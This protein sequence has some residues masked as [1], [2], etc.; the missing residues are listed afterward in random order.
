MAEHKDLLRQILLSGTALVAAGIAGG[1]CLSAA[2]AAEFTVSDQASFAAAMQSI[3]LDHANSHTLNITSSF[4]MTGAVA[5]VVLDDGQS[6][7]INGNGNT[8][9]G[10]NQFRPFFISSSSPTSSGGPT[11][12][13]SNLNIEGGAATGGAGA[14]GGMGA[15]GGLFVD[16][17]TTVVLDLVNFRNNSATGGSA[18]DAGGGGGL[19]G[20]GGAG[21]T[22]GGGGLYGEGGSSHSISLDPGSGAGGGGALGGGGPGSTGGGGGGGGF[23]GVGGSADSGTAPGGGGGGGF[24]GASGG[25][26]GDL[27]GGGG[28]GLTDAGDNSGGLYGGAGGGSPAQGG[29]GGDYE[30]AGEDA[31][32]EGGGGGGGGETSPGGAGNMF[33]GGGGG[34]QA[35]SGN[36]SGGAGGFGG[37]GGGAG[38]G[39]DTSSGSNGGAGG[40]FGGG[41]GAEEDSTA[42][43][44][45]GGDFGG[46]GGGDD[47]NGG[48]GGFGGGGGSSVG[49][50]AGNGGFGGG[51]AS[52]L[53]GAQ[54][55]GGFGGGDATSSGGGGGAAFGGAVFVRDGGTLVIRGSGEMGGG[56]V[57]GGAGL[58][59][60]GTGQA[61][62]TGIFLQ[63]ATVNFQ[64]RRREIQIIGDG[65]ADDTGNGANSG[66]LVKSGAGTTVL[67]GI[68]SYSGATTVDGGLLTV[69]GSLQTSSGV[70]V[71]SGAVI[72][73]TGI[74]PATVINRGGTFAPGNSIGTI[75][76]RGDLSF[77][78]GSV[79]QVE[80]NAD[81]SSDRIQVNGTATIDKTAKVSVLAQ[82]GT[83]RPSTRY[84]I[85]KT[86][87][88]RRGSFDSDV[89][90]N[91]AFL[92]GKLSYDTNNVYLTL[93]PIRGG[94]H[95]GLCAVAV[96][97]NQ[98]K[99]A[100]A[101]DALPDNDPLL[102]AVLNQT[103]P[104]A[105]H[106]FD[107]LSGELHASLGGALI[108]QSWYM[109][110]LVMDR[111]VQAS[112]GNTLGSGGPQ[113]AALQ[114]SRYD[115]QMMAL[116]YDA[117]DLAAL[118]PLRNTGPTVWSQ[119]FGSWGGLDGDHNA[120][121]L[122]STVG[123]VVA[124]IDTEIVQGWR[125]GLA[126]G[127]SHAS[128][129]AA[130][131]ASTASV[132]A[133][134][135]LVYGGGEIGR[136]ALRAGG[137]WSWQ[138]IDTNRA[139]AF[140][141][142]FEKEKSSYDGNQAQA[143][144]ELA[145][146]LLP[147]RGVSAEPFAGLAYV[148]QETDGFTE[149][150]R[151]AS[152]TGSGY[153]EDVTYSSL[154][155]RAGLEMDMLG[156]RFSPRA[157]LA[158]LHAF[159]RPDTGLAL[160]FASGGTGFDI[161]GVPIAQDSAL[162]EAGLDIALSA[163]ATLSLSYEGQ[164]ASDGDE[165]GIEGRARWKF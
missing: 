149:S 27:G 73:G 39:A 142:F 106:A 8:I 156:I 64:P 68:N 89:A 53:S 3:A 150:G 121:P 158:W 124:G 154:G 71:D 141:G 59:A 86:T 143:F 74:L 85:L 2:E 87:D 14:G 116:G 83:Y 52:S 42:Q 160:A 127:Y 41:G 79:Y 112:Y 111:L 49:G 61:A 50:N 88:S 82:S 24:G 102:I 119:G 152:L 151:I 164:L 13:I 153:S 58:G 77:E 122:D 145:Y 155:L 34:G 67:N 137:A 110:R 93:V 51:G 44:G 103:A 69:N 57:T 20:S 33:G 84:T 163:A 21:A 63:N 92:E 117:D 26:Y 132:D 32:L 131:R 47:A 10:N 31:P 134:H 147:G 6:L 30:S 161:Q 100:H 138:K 108:N 5:P 98:C 18:N 94:G 97:P 35:G 70:T 159:D 28:G 17:N 133:Y 80:V 40:Y 36:A 72:S 78:S 91:L 95:K 148:H 115:A 105:R 16:Q 101:L 128:L 54:G 1:T 29:Q 60:G 146:R 113:A 43:G 62:G 120:A 130:A 45:N 136:I 76:V 15:G 165:H 96:S 55:A 104:G 9:D 48:N 81:R 157:S 37:G 123:G 22:G 99:V 162:I 7:T 38:S 140:P 90:T 19:G 66:S 4:T 125:A 135:L 46:G 114:G 109:R 23:Y 25:G 107:A 75:R 118:Q 126:G 11:V 139:V 129:D 12:T 65:I 56:T 144:G